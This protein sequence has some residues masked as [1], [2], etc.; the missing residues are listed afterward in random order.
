MVVPLIVGVV[1]EN[2]G[3]QYQC[4]QEILKPYA[5]DYVLLDSILQEG[6]DLVKAQLF[7][8]GDK[9][10]KYAKGVV[11]EL[12]GLRH[13]VQTYLQTERKYCRLFVG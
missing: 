2:P 3:I 7:G 12:R 1:A 9:N 8:R 11:E 13:H 6:R 10:V 5:N 4:L